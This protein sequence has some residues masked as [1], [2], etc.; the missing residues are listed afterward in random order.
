MDKAFI[1]VSCGF[2]L[3]LHLLT[4]SITLTEENTAYQIC[5]PWSADKFQKTTIALMPSGTFWLYS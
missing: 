5:P 3:S 1:A 2:V 4:S